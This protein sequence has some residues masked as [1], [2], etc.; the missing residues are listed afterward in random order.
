MFRGCRPPQLGLSCGRNIVVIKEGLH[1]GRS[2]WEGLLEA[3]G[4]HRHPS[5]GSDD[6]VGADN[7]VQAKASV[8]MEIQGPLELASLGSARSAL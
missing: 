5:D 4:E 1:Q 8:K 3:L 7:D 2:G 6:A